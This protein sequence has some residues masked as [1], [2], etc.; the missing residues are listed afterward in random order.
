MNFLNKFW[1]IYFLI[2][3]ILCLNNKTE[4]Y[5]IQENINIIYSYN[6]PFIIKVW[7]CLEILRLL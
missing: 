2:T 6:I 1:I 4:I 5:T 7:I 3:P